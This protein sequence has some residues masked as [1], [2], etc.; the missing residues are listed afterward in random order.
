MN[1]CFSCGNN[2]TELTIEVNKIYG[3]SSH[4]RFFEYKNEKE[5]GALGEFIKKHKLPICCASAVTTYIN[6]R[7]LHH[8]PL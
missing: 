6:N 7:Y 4:Q 8:T 5:S 1:I 2:L 3:R